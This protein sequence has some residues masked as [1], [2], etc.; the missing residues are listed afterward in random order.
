MRIA[1]LGMMMALIKA[2]KP[3]EAAAMFQLIQGKPF[4]KIR[5]N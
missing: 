5:I 3:E 4:S 1:P 2:K